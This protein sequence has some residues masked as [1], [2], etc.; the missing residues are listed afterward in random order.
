MSQETVD[1]LLVKVRLILPA[2]VGQTAELDHQETREVAEM[3]SLDQDA[4]PALTSQV[5]LKVGLEQ[6][7]IQ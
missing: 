5:D 7:S 1:L 6:V 4:L 3:A 2:E